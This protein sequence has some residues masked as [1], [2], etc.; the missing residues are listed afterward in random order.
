MSGFMKWNRCGFQKSL[1]IA[2]F[3]AVIPVAKTQAQEVRGVWCSRF[4]WAN[5]T[6][7]TAKNNIL[8]VLDG[9]V[10]GHFNCFFFQVRGECD[11]FYPSPNEPWAPQISNPDGANP[12]WDPVAYAVTQAHNRNIKIHAYFNVHT[13]WGSSTNP[14]TSGYPNHIFYQHGNASDS[15]HRDWLLYDDTGNPAA[16]NEYWWMNPG[17][18]A[19]DAHVRREAAYVVAN[20]NVDGLHFDR[21]RMS[22]EN[23]GKNPIAVARWD[24]PA[25]PTANDGPGNPNH[26]DWASFMRDAVTRQIINICGQCW[27]I[28]PAVVLSSSP[29]GLWE[30]SS[31]Y[32]GLGGYSSGFQW[33]YRRGQDAKDWMLKGAQDFIVPQIYWD[34]GGSKP[35]FTE[36]FND[37]LAGAN[38]AG[39]YLVPGSNM[40]NG[41]AEVEAHALLARST[42]GNSKGHNIWHSGNTLY[43]TW[44]AAGH[45]YASATPA[46][47]TFPWRSTEGVI[48][49]HVF[50]D[51]AET[52]PAIDAWITRNG[53]TWTALS[54]G[55]GFFS[56]LRVPPGT[57]TLTA[58]HPSLGTLT[59]SNVVVTAG[60]ATDVVLKPSS[61]PPA[62]PTSLVST[63]NSSNHTVT[64]NWTDNA[65]NENSY[66]LYRATVSGGPFTLL[67]TLAANTTSYLDDATLYVTDTSWAGNFYYRV[68]AVNNGG[69]SAYSN[70]RTV[71]ISWVPDVILESRSWSG[72]VPGGYTEGLASGGTWADTAAKSLVTG[73]RVKG[74][75][76]RWTGTGSNGSFANFTPNILT[77]GIYE[78]LVTGPNA[79]IAPNAGSPGTVISVR[80]GTSVIASRTFDNSRTNTALADKWMSLTPTAL[81]SQF[82]LG[83]GRT[84]RLTNNNASSANSGQRFNID[85]IRLRFVSSAALES[86]IASEEWSLYE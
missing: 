2:F 21:A 47:P 61:A 68:R 69:N 83:T 82:P 67:D 70:T 60:L 31:Y 36:V 75:G 63:V 27:G 37:W 25:T 32:Q 57:Y 41:Q 35:D 22:G 78:V 76:G 17:I 49:G 28:K 12:G 59:A 79:T 9:M 7:T 26:L 72:G 4:Q 48:T 18:P 51:G 16:I 86:S 3:M 30:Y 1:L 65:S 14:S 46:F 39:R 80:Q 73:P 5:E 43:S 24:N 15:A 29:L 10:T 45:P 66:E 52:T 38:A 64:L 74:V 40:S 58:T 19:A 44:S 11:V 71:A 13:I 33:G 53:S 56:F 85:A 54:S 84:I 81:T 23:F 34:N 50:M 62:A 42:G 8:S 77:S 6:Q 20:Y 55:D